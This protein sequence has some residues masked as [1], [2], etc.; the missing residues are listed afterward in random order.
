MIEWKTRKIGFRAA[1]SKRHFA[2]SCEGE[3]GADVSKYTLTI[4][5]IQIIEICLSNHALTAQNIYHGTLMTQN[6]QHAQ[7]SKVKQS[8]AKKKED[9]TAAECDNISFHATHL[10]IAWHMILCCLQALVLSIFDR[11]DNIHLVLHR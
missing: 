1:C 7:L 6:I 3:K 9:T 10:L 4:Q 11:K 5:N 2:P 8:H